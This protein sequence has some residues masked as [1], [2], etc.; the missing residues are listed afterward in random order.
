MSEFGAKSVKTTAVFATVDG[1]NTIV[2]APGAGLAILIL[3]Y[4][5]RI[6]GVGDAFLTDSAGNLFLMTGAAS[7]GIQYQG[8][9]NSDAIGVLKLQTNT[10][11][12]ITNA[13]GV[14][15]FGHVAWRVVQA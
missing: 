14:D 3:N 10:A 13:A 6:V 9:G 1:A 7:P 11:L 5:F 12:V 2:P 15:T 4:N 8:N